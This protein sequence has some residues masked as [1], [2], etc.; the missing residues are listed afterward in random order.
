L[1]RAPPAKREPAC[2]LSI[3]EA[4]SLRRINSGAG[5]PKKLVPF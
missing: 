2:S 5:H 3:A 4:A 1:T